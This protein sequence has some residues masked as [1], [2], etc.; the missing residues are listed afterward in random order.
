MKTPLRWTLFGPYRGTMRDMSIINYLLSK[1]E[2]EARLEQLH[3]MEHEEDPNHCALMSV[4]D[5]KALDAMSKCG[6]SL[7]NS[8]ALASPTKPT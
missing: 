8:F 1:D 4:E 3:K 5:R 7:A 2:L 6:R